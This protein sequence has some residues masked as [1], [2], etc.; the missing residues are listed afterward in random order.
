[1]RRLTPLAVLLAF[2]LM[3]CP[4]Q[5]QQKRVSYGTHPSCEEPSNKRLTTGIVDI[6]VSAGTIQVNPDPV[7][8]LPGVGV[9]GWKSATHDWKVVFTGKSPLKTTT[10][11]GAAGG[12]AVSS[13]VR[14]DAECT[15]Y[16]Y[17]VIVTPQG[18]G[19][20]DTL[21]PDGEIIPY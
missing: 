1:M 8:Q 14:Q 17:M 13:G 20:P 10:L 16:K 4:Q 7:R 15:T 5:K 6:S 9:M 19:T 12:N 21:D 18:G 2:L 3:G 11:N